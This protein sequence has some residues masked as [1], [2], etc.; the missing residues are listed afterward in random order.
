MLT[1]R[2]CAPPHKVAVV[3]FSEVL[4]DA[5]TGRPELLY[6]EPLAQEPVQLEVSHRLHF[7]T[8]AQPK[9]VAIGQSPQQCDGQAVK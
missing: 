4:S 5:I 8:L 7:G 2:P 1:E 3:H 9:H 6:D